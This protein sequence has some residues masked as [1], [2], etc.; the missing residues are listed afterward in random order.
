[1]KKY[2]CEIP[3]DLGSKGSCLIGGNVAT[4]AAGK[5]FIKYGPLR[6]NI[7]G[8][9]VILANGETLNMM[10]EIRKDNTGYDIK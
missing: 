10:S 1:M 2:D 3:W 8:L 7:L 9:E 4:H 5:Y 6:A